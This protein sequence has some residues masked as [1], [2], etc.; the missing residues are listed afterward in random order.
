[1]P[2]PGI[3]LGREIRYL[4]VYWIWPLWKLGIYLLLLWV[5]SWV[6]YLALMTVFS[7]GT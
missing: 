2:A 3:R 5:V 6:L 4:W 7:A 1:M